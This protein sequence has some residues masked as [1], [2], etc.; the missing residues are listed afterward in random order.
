V[1]FLEE[2]RKPFN[3][4]TLGI[5]IVGV[6]LSLYFYLNPRRDRGISFKKSE[7]SK[8]YSSHSSSPK[9]RLTDE[10]N[11][12]ITQDVSV[13]TFTFWNSGSEA[14]EPAE[15][16]K[17]LRI[18]LNNPSRILDTS[19]VKQTDSSISRFRL[20]SDFEKT[21][22]PRREI[23]VSWEHFDPKQGLTIQI[24]FASDSPP[25]FSID[26]AILG[27]NSLR[28]VNTLTGYER[29]LV[30][31]L[32]SG[33]VGI[34]IGFRLVRTLRSPRPAFEKW[35]DFISAAFWLALLDVFV[36]F[37]G[38]IILSQLRQPPAF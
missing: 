36:M 1:R 18:I 19:I 32:P 11:D 15:V 3:A 31:A 22:A 28:D 16:R 35:D 23:T 6:L 24:I 37:L 26:G 14:I 2:I 12:P 9:I 5:A 27:V 20:A 4:I 25:S 21:I 30:F 13:V 34:L 17:N 7:I 10:S 8:I 33:I 29:F 38:V